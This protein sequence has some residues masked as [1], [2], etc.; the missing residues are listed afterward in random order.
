MNNIPEF[1]EISDNVFIGTK[2]DYVINKHNK[3][4]WFICATN[5]K[6]ITISPN[7]ILRKDIPSCGVIPAEALMNPH[8]ESRRVQA[9]EALHQA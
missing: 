8:H 6:D 5:T 3:D 4:V 2:Y 9:P 7:I 1:I